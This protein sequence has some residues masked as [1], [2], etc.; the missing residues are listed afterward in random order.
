M[1]WFRKAQDF[2][3]S[4]S[5]SNFR[6]VLDVRSSLTKEVQT[7]MQDLNIVCSIDLSLKNLFSSDAVYSRLFGSGKHNIYQ[8]S[9]EELKKIDHNILSSK[10]ITV[11]L[12][13]HG[14]RMISDELI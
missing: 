12:S 6:I 14:V 5:F 8:V 1:K 2:F 4:T 7:L 9:D 3:A 10:S 13:N 11:A